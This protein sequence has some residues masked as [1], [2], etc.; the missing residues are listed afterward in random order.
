MAGPSVGPVLRPALNAA[1]KALTLSIASL[2]VVASV[3]HEVRT[4]LVVSDCCAGTPGCSTSPTTPTPTPTPTTDRPARPGVGR[5]RAVGDGGTADD[6]HR[7]HRDTAERQ[8][9]SP[10]ANPP[11]AC[12]DG[13]PSD[14][15]ESDVTG[16]GFQLPRTSRVRVATKRP[17]SDRLRLSARGRRCGTIG[18]ATDPSRHIRQQQERK[19]TTEFARTRSG[20]NPK[21]RKR[22]RP[23][24]GDP[25]GRGVLSARHRSRGDVGVAGVLRRSCWSARGPRGRAI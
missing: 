25:R 4:A 12:R 8:G 19:L 14:E 7:H 15:H 6:P 5:G 23:R 17:R 18:G 10:G 2:L 11:P 20:Q 1:T 16:S 24:S 13:T 22:T 21:Q 3:S 9:A